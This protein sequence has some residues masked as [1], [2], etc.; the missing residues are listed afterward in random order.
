L[1]ALIR[2][3]KS[4]SGRERNCCFLNLGGKFADISSV[5]GLDFPDDGRAVARVDW[6]QDGDLDFWISNRSGPQLR[7]LRNDVP[8][9]HNYLS[10]R[11]QGNGTTTNRDAIAARV[12]VVLAGQ[13]GPNTSRIKTLRAGDGFMAQSSKWLHF[14][15]GKHTDIERL[16][17]RWPG[18]TVEEFTSVE[19]N[20]RYRIRQGSG[21]ADPWEAV[22]RRVT[23]EPSLLVEPR[24][25]E[26]SRVVSAAR[27][28]MPRLDYRTFG[29]H[30]ATVRQHA[31]PT[32]HSSPLLINLW[33]SWCMP[34]VAELNEL[35]EREADLRAAG[36]DVV[37]LSVDDLDAIGSSS[38]QA[39]TQLVETI[40]FP[41]A[42]GM[43]TTATAEKLQLVL[44]HLFDLHR[45]LAVPSSI[46]LDSSGRVA[47]IY[48][49]RVAMDQ[50]LDDVRMVTDSPDQLGSSS[51]FAGRWYMQRKRL[52]PFDLAW[53][54][55]E[56]APLDDAIEYIQQN[57]Q[58]LRDHFNLHKLLVLVGNGRLA[59]GEAEHAATL[60]HQALKIDV[61]YVD[62]QNNLAWLLA[63]HA[64][65]KI[66]D[67]KK[68]VRLAEMA[69]AT[70]GDVP[71]L[72]DTLAAAYAAGGRFD[73]AITSA[74]KA[75]GLA[76]ARAQPQ[77]ARKIERRLRLYE[78]GR[79]FRENLS[80]P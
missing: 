33:T 8:I 43:A 51:R 1:H 38:L 77:L 66:R 34:C 75:I 79:P 49:G 4:F 55:V 12:E 76:Q 80:L 53:K 23:L 2:Q 35:T 21:Q 16:V 44:D 72:L 59:R 45:P 14:G 48:R 70:A 28:P 10:V 69:I 63:T 68:A 26:R 71:S 74:K 9:K 56:Q 20:R 25:A 54:L 78:A 19:P 58:L 32:K 50:L 39:A 73:E 40:D 62:A 52:S 60:Y 42:S 13:R 5:S 41:F 61:D 30:D 15:L 22:P 29:G 65:E 46:L 57:K 3:G 27:L 6:D 7:F 11:L 67:E 31:S 37:A 64:D 18:G 47:V 17:V 36:L 24:T